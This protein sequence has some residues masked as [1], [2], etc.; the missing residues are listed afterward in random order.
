MAGLLKTYPHLINNY[1]KHN[2]VLENTEEEELTKAER[3]EAWRE[4]E[5]EIANSIEG[6]ANTDVDTSEQTIHSSLKELVN[7]EYVQSDK[8]LSS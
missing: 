1:Y 2:S 8:E 6:T 7:L 5:F 3:L 4:Y